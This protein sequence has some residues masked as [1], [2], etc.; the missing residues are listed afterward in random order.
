LAETRELLLSQKKKK[1]ASDS[2]SDSETTP[3]PLAFFLRFVARL[4]HLLLDMAL[5]NRIK[6]LEDIDQL[7]EINGVTLSG[8]SELYS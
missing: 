3:Q 5:A 8:A 6:T 1:R 2:Y 7:Q 4:C